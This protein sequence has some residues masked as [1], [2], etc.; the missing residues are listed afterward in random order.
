MSG[1]GISWV[2]CKSA[3]RSWQIT[4]PA[5]HHWVFYCTSC[6]PTNSVKALANHE[7]IKYLWLQTV[8]ELNVIFCTCICLQLAVT[9]STVIH[10]RQ[11]FPIF[12]MQNFIQWFKLYGCIRFFLSDVYVFVITVDGAAFGWNL[13]M[14]RLDHLYRSLLLTKF[15]TKGWGKPENLKRFDCFFCFEI[16][17]KFVV[18]WTSLMH[19]SLFW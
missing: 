18:A 7:N 2:I 13:N 16:L 1:S 15:F 5:P 11:F 6:R 9:A 8:H 4:M 12:I 3:P 10:S 14:S 17:N 19:C